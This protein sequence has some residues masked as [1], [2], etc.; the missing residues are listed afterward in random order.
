MRP[1]QSKPNSKTKLPKQLSADAMEF[2]L[3]HSQILWSEPNFKGLV[4]RFVTMLSESFAVKYA[5]FK[6]LTKNESQLVLRRGPIRFQDVRS[7]GDD[8]MHA[9]VKALEEMNAQSQDA[10]D[11][12]TNLLVGGK[13]ISFCIIGDFAVQAYLLA[14][15]KAESP[16][17]I[18]QTGVLDFLVRQVQSECRWL[19]KL[20]KT[21]ALVYRDDLTGLYNYRYLDLSLDSEVRRSGRFESKFCLLFLDLDHFK[22]I[23]D[24][25]GHLAGSSVLKQVS[26]TLLDA[27]REVDVVIRY[28]GDEFVIIL[29]GAN[30]TQARLVAE[31]IRRMI[32]QKAYRIDNDATVHV[33]ASI[34]I[35]AYPEHGPD[36]AALLR[37]A[38]ENMYLSKREGKNRVT[39]IHAKD[40]KVKRPVLGKSRLRS[41][42]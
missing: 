30:G 26:E 33:T 9:A 21:Q 5:S 4:K 41:E 38:D 17:V 25:Y 14:W 36:K 39:F 16:T 11:G 18:E 32:D 3:S 2:L 29:L 13:S 42:D 28:G 27:V 20:D 19:G 7:L 10:L 12:V 15:E 6:E 31:R 34:G 37:A 8:A 1:V 24:R 40:G 35:A 23:N 22:P